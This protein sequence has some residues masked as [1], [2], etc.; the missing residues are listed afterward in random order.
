VPLVILGA[1]LL[2][3]FVLLASYGL[4]L[5]LACVIVAMLLLAHLALGFGWTLLLKLVGVLSRR[6]AMM[7][8]WLTVIITSV[9]LVLVRD[10]DVI[11]LRWLGVLFQWIIQMRRILLAWL[12]IWRDLKRVF[13][14]VT[15]WR[16]L[17]ADNILLRVNVGVNALLY[18]FVH[19]LHETLLQVISWLANGWL[20]GYDALAQVRVGLHLRKDLVDRRLVIPDVS[21]L[22]WVFH[23]GICPLYRWL[24]MTLVGIFLHIFISGVPRHVQRLILVFIWRC[25]YVP[26]RSATLSATMSSRSC[27]IHIKGLVLGRVI[28]DVVEV[29]RFIQEGLEVRKHVCLIIWCY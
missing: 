4:M 22:L 17:K 12:N 20:L 11:S 26:G 27:P 13:A 14:L 6:S 1:L 8:W 15:P 5:L 10:H 2:G 21:H 24:S 7:W 25:Q 9:Q 19:Q 29:H 23:W 16:D 18:H 28:E 3:D